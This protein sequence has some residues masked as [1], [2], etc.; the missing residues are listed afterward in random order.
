MMQ[1]PLAP[2]VLIESIAGCNIVR[3]GEKYLVVP[4]SLGPIDFGQV[5]PEDVVGVIVSASLHEARRVAAR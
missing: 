2:P 4:Q 5:R 3:V 1:R